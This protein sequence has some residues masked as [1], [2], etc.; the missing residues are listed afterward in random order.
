MAAPARPRR[1][2]LVY[3]AFPKTHY[4]MQYLYPLGRMRAFMPPLGLLTI[5]ALT[6]SDVEIRL[7]DV[8]CEPLEDDDIAWADLVCFSAMLTQRRSLFA[9]AT[10]CRAQNKTIVFGGPYPT[11]CPEQCRPY[12]DVLVLNEGEVT[13]PRFLADLERGTPQARYASEEKPDVTRVPVQPFHVDDL[14]DYTRVPLQFSR[15]CPFQCEFCDIIVMF[16][17]RPRTKTAEQFCRELE[18]VRATGYRGLVF[19][20]DDNFIGNEKEVRKLLPAMRAWNRA[21]GNPFLYCTEASVNLADDPSLVAEM[22]EA[23]FRRVFIGIETPSM[24]AL[25]QTRK[26]QNTKRPLERAVEAIQRGGLLV[27]AG[28]IVGFDSDGDD[29]FA[30]QEEF[31]TRAA[32]PNAIVSVLTALPGTPLYERMQRTGRLKAEKALDRDWCS[33]TNIVTRMPERRL[34][35]GH[36]ELL[37]RLNAPDAYFARA[38]AQLC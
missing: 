4:G 12:C 31:I 38:I 13:W 17:R 35:E 16:G 5:A 15:G 34:L 11:A 36:R 33:A 25:Q 27:D 9:L 10:R 7:V 32:I 20:V 3:L 21:H 30:R 22:V 6:P 14:S 24:E 8:N 1:L 29:I 26:F 28:F 2:L 37:V 18:A 23:S 19:V